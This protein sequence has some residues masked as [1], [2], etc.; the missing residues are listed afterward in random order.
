MTGFADLAKGGLALAFAGFVHDIAVKAPSIAGLCFG[1]L[2]PLRAYRFTGGIP[3]DR[4]EVS[5]ADN[6]YPVIAAVSA[7]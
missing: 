5:R 1:T 7:Y 2:A 3:V 4:Y 6:T